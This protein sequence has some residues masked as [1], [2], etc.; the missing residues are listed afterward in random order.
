MK[1][2][3]LKLNSTNVQVLATVIIGLGFAFGAGLVLEDPMPVYGIVYL[4][5]FLSI[6]WRYQ[7]V[8]LGLTLGCAP[9]QEDLSSGL[10]PFRFSLGEINLILCAIVFA[11]RCVTVQRGFKLGPTMFPSFIY[12]TI[13]IGSSLPQWHADTVVPSLFQMVL[14][15]FIA[16]L[17]FSHFYERVEDLRLGFYMLIGTCVFISCFGLASGTF[18]ILGLHKNGAGSS[19]AAG[20]IVSAELWLAAGKSRQKSRLFLWNII[21]TAGLIF[22]LSRGAWIGAF[23]G[24]LTLILLRGKFKFLLQFL[25]GMIPLII[26]FWNLLPQESKEQATNFDA[27]AVNISARYESIDF[28]KQLFQ[29]NPIYGNGVGLRK[30][31]DATNIIWL[32]LAETGVPG[33][34]AFLLIHVVFFLMIYKTQAQMARNSPLYS[35][36]AIGAGELMNKLV[37]GI[38][39]HYWSRGPL[40]VA[41]ATVGMA[42]AVFFSERKRIAA[43][44]LVAVNLRAPAPP[45]PRVPLPVR[46]GGRRP[47]RTDG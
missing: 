38:V 33:L 21:V 31:Y 40:L 6:A 10:G 27:K 16:P 42:T 9:F 7:A 19:L 23:A 25:V 13:C 14:Y 45:T 30:E 5:I 47:M 35:Y 32:T 15:L 20:L 17:V 36:L 4:T 8:A 1:I 34:I 44:N 12:L 2:Q 37:H 29:K 3:E 18:Y 39:D 24:V 28:A 26:I 41:W 43:E 46:R 22:A 11:Y